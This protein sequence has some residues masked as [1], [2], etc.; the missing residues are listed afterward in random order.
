MKVAQKIWL[1]F[2][3]SVLLL[4]ALLTLIVSI[5]WKQESC[6]VNGTKYNS[7]DNVLGYL[8]NADCVC[9]DDGK[10][11]CELSNISKSFLDSSDFTT[12]S[13]TFE[14]EFSNSLSNAE[15]SIADEVVF[16][17]VSQGSKGLEIIVEK[18]DSCTSSS[19][20]PSQVGF[21]SL[22]DEDLVLTTIETNDPSTYTEPCIVKNIFLLSD[23]NGNVSDSFKVYYRDEDDNVYLADMCVYE[24]KLHNDSDTYLS[25][26]NC[27][28]CQ[29][30][31]GKNSC[32][33]T[34]K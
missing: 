18:V 22:S 12:K 23:I 10:V 9:G 25:G 1:L 7:G 34:C 21:Y 13:L 32:S 6:T 4:G 5:D 24:G 20:I 2:L 27:T 31:S 29:C 11:E 15:T 17:S 19:D 33:S 26:D 8:E 16:R 14:A 3:S 30:I 28:I